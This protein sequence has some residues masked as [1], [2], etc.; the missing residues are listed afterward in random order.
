MKATPLAAFAALILAAFCAFQASPASA[1]GANRADI[2][3][4]AGVQVDESA[5][6]GTAAQTQ[7]FAAAQRSGFERLVKRITL[8]QDQARLGIPSPDPATL[9]RLASSV[10]VENERRSGTRYIARLTVRYNAEAVRTLLRQAGFA[11][12]ETRA[13]PMLIAPL[14]DGTTTP[15]LLTE[16]RTV[17]SEGGYGQELV[18]LA[19][20]PATAMSADWAALR[21]YAQ[22]EAAAAAIVAVLRVQGGTATASLREVGP[23]GITDRGAVS[24]SLGGDANTQ[25]VGLQSLAQQTNAIIQDAWK[26]RTDAT[27]ATGVQRARLS[28]SVLYADQREW[29]RIKSGLEGA[30][31]TMVSEIRIE[32]VGREG[33]LVSFSFTGERAALTAELARR[34]IALQ[35]SQFGPVL[36][37]VAH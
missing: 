5:A 34:G 35:D 26:A 15:E 3:A 1:Q 14:G 32:A 8:P 7:G 9:D 28:A 27:S 20:A 37:A 17:W 10:D 18:P 13:S 2:Y 6:N 12:V 4:V 30:A 36:R 31:G 16:W 23:N 11:I 24:A 22:A 29:E 19:L 33:A 21:P 25:R